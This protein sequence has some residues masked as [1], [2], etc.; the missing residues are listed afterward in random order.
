MRVPLLSA[1]ECTACGSCLPEH[2]LI[3]LCAQTTP[4]C[5]S[6]KLL[7]LGV[8]Y[9]VHC[10]YH[11]G[12]SR[13]LPCLCRWLDDNGMSRVPTHSKGSSPAA[14]S[15]ITNSGN[16]GP[17]R[18]SAPQLRPSRLQRTTRADDPVD[19]HHHQTPG[20]DDQSSESEAAEVLLALADTSPDHYD[21]PATSANAPGSMDV[22][23]SDVDNG[24]DDQDAA[25]KQCTQP[26]LRTTMYA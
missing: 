18:C 2:A 25:G 12:M 19:H 9:V 7:Y 17:V 4:T 3:V 21:Q 8:L 1:S 26:L 10:P 11:Y 5:N 13:S 14:D 6:F 20:A 24:D 15:S 16:T 23:G 22:D